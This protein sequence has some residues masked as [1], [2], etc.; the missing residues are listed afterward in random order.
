[1]TTEHPRSNEEKRQ[2]A[3]FAAR[4]EYQRQS[5]WLTQSQAWAGDPFDLPPGVEPLMPERRRWEYWRSALP[6]AWT[7]RQVDAYQYKH[8]CGG[9]VL[10]NLHEAGLAL[11]VYWLD[12]LGFCEPCH[13]P[14][15][16]VPQPGD[17]AWFVKNSHYAMV[18]SVSADGKRFDSI[19]GNQGLTLARPS[20]KL[21]RGRLLSS[22][23]VFYSIEP[24]LKDAP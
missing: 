16:N 23:A 5:F 15:V 1:M 9:F 4:F 10:R 8:W 20:I 7:D 17:V 18:E 11:G 13:L 21:H 24:F 12:G 3:I 2:A 14:R 6:P 19:D 22:V